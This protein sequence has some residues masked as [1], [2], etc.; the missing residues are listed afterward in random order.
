MDPRAFGKLGLTPKSHTI[1]II[2]GKSFDAHVWIEHNG[3]IVDYDDDVLRGFSMYSTPS[4]QVIR[5]PFSKQLQDELKPHIAKLGNERIRAMRK[6]P[7][8][9]RIEF[10]RRVNTTGGFCNLKALKY[11]QKHSDAVIII[12][13]LGFRGSDNE[14]RYEYG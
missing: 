1:E 3:K 11:K 13:S 2:K 7:K 9:I 14:I 6:Y 12:G 5:R 4:S 8:E 10:M